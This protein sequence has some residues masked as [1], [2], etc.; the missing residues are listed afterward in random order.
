MFISISLNVSPLL[1]LVFV[2]FS[3][4]SCVSLFVYLTRSCT[5]HFL[6]LAI[7]S[8]PPVEEVKTSEAVQEVPYQAEESAP[9]ATVRNKF[10]SRLRSFLTT[11]QEPAAEETKAEVSTFFFFSPF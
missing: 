11:S 9:P 1:P 4:L 5:A 7:M 10:A 6:Q 8:A 3:P 2:L